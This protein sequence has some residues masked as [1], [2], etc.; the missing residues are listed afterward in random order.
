[1]NQIAYRQIKYL[2]ISND[3]A[4]EW[5]TKLAHLWVAKRKKKGSR[6]NFTI[7]D[8]RL[9]EIGIYLKCL[10]NGVAAEPPEPQVLNWL[11]AINIEIQNKNHSNYGFLKELEFYWESYCD[12]SFNKTNVY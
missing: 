10:I 4:S 12:Y 9:E 11:I 3:V 6:K 8:V 1:M 2:D 5:R 7:H